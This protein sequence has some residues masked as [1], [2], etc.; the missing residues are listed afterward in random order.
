MY[1][2]LSELEKMKSTAVLQ[3]EKSKTVYQD[4]FWLNG[5]QYEIYRAAMYGL[6][7]F[8]RK[9]LLKMTVKKKRNIQRFFQ[10]CQ[11]VLNVWKQEIVNALFEKLCTI[12]FKNFASN[13][14]DTIFKD[15]NMGVKSFGR[16]TSESFRSQFTF[17]QLGI[18]REKIIQ[19][20]IREGLLPENFYQLQ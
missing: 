13:P 8:S 2:S 9:E 1:Q 5:Y 4:K 14:F 17:T 16:S 18:S 10:K 7:A 15:T 20:L 12:P 19:K 11:R 3:Q 6:A